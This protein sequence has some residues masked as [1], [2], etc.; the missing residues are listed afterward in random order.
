MRHPFE[1]LRPEYSQLLSAMVVRKECRKEVDDVAVKLLDFRG[2]YEPVSAKNGVPVVFIAT[3]FEREASSDFS[4]NAGQ[5]WPLT[6]I[7]KWVPHNGPFRTW[8]DSAIAA[9]HLNGLDAVGA[10]KWTWELMCFYG[11]LFN[12][13]GYRDEHHM[14]TP[15]L[16][17]GTNIQ[18]VGK[19]VEDGK[20]DPAHMDSQLGIIPVARRMVEIEPALALPTVIPTPAHS[21]LSAPETGTDTKWIQGAMNELGWEP[22][23]YVDGSYG[24]DTMKAVEMFQRS[25]GITVDGLAGPETI[26]HLKAAVA[27]AK[28]PAA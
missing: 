28:G 12:G 3:S 5:G 2:R 13:E 4:K 10:G 27:A 19:Y 1:I 9:Y 8:A 18:T 15:Y 20:F 21:G 22:S 17:G 14:H 26:E 25:Y 6:S 7:S 24:R 11:E 16:W 23:L